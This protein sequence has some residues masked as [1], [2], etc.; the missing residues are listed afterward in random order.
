MSDSNPPIAVSE[1][2]PIKIPLGILLVLIGASAGTFGAWVMLRMDVAS[3]KEQM[4][5]VQTRQERDHELL[6]GI[7]RTLK[8]AKL[9]V[10]TE[11]NSRTMAA[12]HP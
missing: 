1:K 12:V 5:E 6:V 2:T 3:L 4:A 8:N 7:E 10:T 11:G 9:I